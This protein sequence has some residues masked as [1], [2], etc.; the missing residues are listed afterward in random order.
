MPKRKERN[1]KWFMLRVTDVKG[2][3]LDQYKNSLLSKCETLACREI[4]D[5]EAKPHYHSVHMTPVNTMRSR[6]NKLGW[7]GNDNHAISFL[8]D[9]TDENWL[10]CLR[11]ICKGESHGVMPDIVVNTL[12]LSDDQ[13]RAYHEEYWKHKVNPYAPKSKSEESDDIDERKSKSF[14]KALDYVNRN[15]H[16]I[17]RR[18]KTDNDL[19]HVATCL[20]YYYRDIHRCQPNNFQLRCM[21][22]SI[23][24]QMIS[25]KSP[26]AFADWASRYASDVMGEDIL[27]FP[28]YLS[29]KKKSK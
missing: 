14:D 15:Y 11:Y 8:Y 27:K 5:K 1:G 29:S 13:I 9:D 17:P 16:I 21:A 10:N 7:N 24:G 3:R 20:V 18:F 26:E 4:S 19:L 28:N 25:E 23:Y 6:L 12:N 22:N 2:D